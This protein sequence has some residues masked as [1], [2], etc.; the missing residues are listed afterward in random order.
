LSEL[1]RKLYD[2]YLLE[3]LAESE[4]RGVD[5]EHEVSKLKGF[6]AEAGLKFSEIQDEIE[7]LRNTLRNANANAN[8]E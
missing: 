4:R 5:M 8:K 2:Q 6:A 7:H 3:L 1:W